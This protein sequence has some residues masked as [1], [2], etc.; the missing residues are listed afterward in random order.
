M[1]ATSST[2]TITTSPVWRIMAVK[3]SWSHRLNSPERKTTRQ[4]ATNKMVN[5][6]RTNKHWSCTPPWITKYKWISSWYN[7]HQIKPWSYC[8]F[9]FIIVK[10]NWWW[11]SL[12]LLFW[13]PSLTL[14]ERYGHQMDVEMTSFEYWVSTVVSV[15][16]R[17]KIR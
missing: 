11:T 16:I 3:S 9:Y 7:P 13:H 2:V 4:S 17:Y 1:F 12:S 10:N 6:S 8:K 5:V 14:F 15:Q